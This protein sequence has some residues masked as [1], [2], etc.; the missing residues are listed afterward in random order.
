MIVPT[1]QAVA[2]T[3]KN[4]LVERNVQTKFLSSNSAFVQSEPAWTMA[5]PFA[6]PPP[7]IAISPVN[8]ASAAVSL[9]EIQRREQDAQYQAENQPAPMS[10][11]EI[12]EQERKAEEA[13]QVEAEF[14][15][16]WMEEQARLKIESKPVSDLA[17][18]HKRTKKKN[19][20]AGSKDAK[21]RKDGQKAA[22]DRQSTTSRSKAEDKKPA[23]MA[24]AGVAEGDKQHRK[25]MA[26]S[27]PNKP[28]KSQHNNS[29]TDNVP[30][31]TRSNHTR[32]QPPS[33]HQN[34]SHT[35]NHDRPQPPVA[36]LNS[37]G[38]TVPETVSRVN[39]TAPVFVPQQSVTPPVFNPRAAAFVPP[40]VNGQR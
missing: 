33:K 20:P 29:S 15:R 22:G 38:H 8:Y 26:Q 32:A 24:S 7:P 19:P 25:S 5:A 10:I 21:E 40:S 12:Q 1:R 3:R 4:R 11:R 6:T 34:P 23:Q 37:N 13:R 30:S 17:G 39:V 36:K 35:H 18:S 16:W 28:R 9:L 31:S 27:S 14:E 2:A